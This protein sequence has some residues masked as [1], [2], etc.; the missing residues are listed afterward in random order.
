MGYAVRSD[1]YR[2]VEWRKRDGTEVVAQELYDHRTDPNED[3][4]LAGDPTQRETIDRLAKTLAA[5]WKE[6]APTR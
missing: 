4:N 3:R 2:Y 6:N 5:G 1:R